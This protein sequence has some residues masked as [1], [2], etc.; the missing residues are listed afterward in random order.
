MVPGLIQEGRYT[1][2]FM[3]LGFLGDIDLDA[4]ERL[5]LPQPQGAYILEVSPGSPA[6]VAGLIAAHPE[7]RRGGDMIIALNGQ[8]INNF[9]DLNSFLVFQ[10]SVGETIEVTLLRDGQVQTVLVTLGARP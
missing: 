3:C 8:P 2:P 4:I 7:T 1:Y 10:A 9:G 6:H 5:G